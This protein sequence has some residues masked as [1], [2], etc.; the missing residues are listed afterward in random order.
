MIILKLKKV[1][2]TLQFR[3]LDVCYYIGTY[4]DVCILFS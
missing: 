4:I 2:I 1:I 3:C